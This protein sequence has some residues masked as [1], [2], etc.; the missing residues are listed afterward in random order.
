MS[1]SRV[2]NH[3]K[4]NDARLRLCARAG[5]CGVWAGRGGMASWL[6]DRQTVQK[7]ALRFLVKRALGPY[8]HADLSLDQVD[9]T[10]RRSNDAETERD[11]V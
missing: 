11:C 6:P 3:H 10:V 8:L 4:R 9:V 2:T 7:R 1:C 5:P